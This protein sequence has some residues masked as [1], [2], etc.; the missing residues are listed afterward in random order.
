MSSHEFARR[1][2]ALAEERD[3]PLTEGLDGLDLADTMLGRLARRGG[4]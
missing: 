2:R 3:L 1:L 4:R